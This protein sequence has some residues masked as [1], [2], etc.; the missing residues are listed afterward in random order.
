MAP[1]VNMAEMLNTDAILTGTATAAAVTVKP[2]VVVRIRF[3]D[4][5]VTVTVDIP[6]AA[7]LLA[8]SVT[9]IVPG[10][11]PALKDAVTPPGVPD[12][13]TLTLPL[14]PFSAVPV[15][16]LAPLLPCATLRLAGDAERAKFGGAVMV[17]AIVAVLFNAPETPVTVTVDAPVTAEALAVSVSV[18]APVVLAGLNDAVTPLGRPDAVRLT[19]PLKPLSGPTV[20]LLAP[21]LP[22]GML[23]LA[24]DA[25]S[26]KLGAAIVSAIVAVL[27]NIPEV[28]VTV[29]VD[30][31]VT[32]EA[33]AVSVTVL[34]PVVLVGLNDAVTPLGRLDAVRLTLPLN[35][36]WG[37]TVIV[38]APL[39]PGLTLRVA[40][41]TASVKLG[42]VT[43]SA[44]VAVLVRVPE[45]PVT[46]IVDVP[47]APEALAVS[48]S[49]LAPVVLAGLNDAVTPLG[50]PD[51][52]RLT[53]PLK[54][55][56]GP[57]VIVLAPLLPCL[58][59]SVGCDAA[60]VN[61]GWPIAAVRSSIRCCPAGVPHPVA[62]S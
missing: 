27:F 32:A 5:P 10:V 2:I 48:V 38:L 23:R 57:T 25:E 11:L 41:A 59:E 13:A 44:I 43:V 60:S 36:F 8:A 54:P 15:I 18:L 30:I 37:P 58:I 1:S 39:P 42:A 34:T 12:A 47:A 21:L 24:G 49:V 28:P 61:A 9:R 46:V 17:R 52:A 50:R 62:R 20:I 53:L 16:V 6:A 55:F 29:I 45:E 26:V 7:G 19:L 3:P 51:A 56:C 22:C 31:P 4:V 40:G 33:L 35:P 14:K